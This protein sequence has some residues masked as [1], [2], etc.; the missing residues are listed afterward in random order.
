MIERLASHPEMYALVLRVP[1]MEFSAGLDRI[2]DGMRPEQY[3]RLQIR[4][5]YDAWA[6]AGWR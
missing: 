6:E 1:F 5:A 2:V 4:A 3:E